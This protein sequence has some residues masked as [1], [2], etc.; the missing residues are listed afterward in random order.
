MDAYADGS[1]LRHNLE[2]RLR[3]HHVG[4]AII[5]RVLRLNPDSH[6]GQRLRGIQR[7]ET[8]PVK[9]FY[10]ACVGKGEFIRRFGRPAWE[11]LKEYGWYD[12]DG[13]R[14]MISQEVVQDRLWERPAKWRCIGSG[15]NKQIVAIS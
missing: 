15:R 8:L 12:R 7:Q 14:V 11:W 9:Q 2:T 6:E 3:K 4:E 10:R 13:R 1:T 5:Q